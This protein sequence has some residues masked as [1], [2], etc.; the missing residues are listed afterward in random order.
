MRINQTET[1]IAAYHSKDRTTLRDK[2]AL[3]ILTATRQGRRSCIGTI[4]AELGIGD[5]SASAR[6]NE[7]KEAGGHAIAG[8]WYNLEA[9]GTMRNPRS[10]VTVEAWALVVPKRE[11][12]QLNLFQ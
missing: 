11:P 10:G 4:A 7:I 2:V 1:A 5:N 8:V 3:C 6:L 9:A 12:E